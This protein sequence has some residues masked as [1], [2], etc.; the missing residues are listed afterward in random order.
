M[1]CSWKWTPFLHKI[2]N[3]LIQVRRKRK[4]KKGEN[5]IMQK[6]DII[7]WDV[8][9]TLLNFKYSQRH[10]LMQCFEIF[11]IPI[12]EAVIDRYDQINDGYWKMLELGKMTKEE[13]LVQRFRT[14]FDELGVTGIDVAAFQNAYEEGVGSIYEYIENSIELCRDLQ[15]KCSQ[16]VVT[17]GTVKVQEKKLRISGLLECMDD[18]FISDKIG[19]P[20]PHP[21]FFQAC[22]EKIP[23]F[24]KNRTIIIGDSLTSDM[25]GGFG[26]GIATCWYNPNA[27]ALPS[28][29]RI[30]YDIRSLREVYGVLGLT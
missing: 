8:D 27:A 20:K 13:L 11:K 19:T 23:N 29:I 2:V 22:F 30:D 7:L 24:Q 1:R 4:E 26:A 5:T 25:K 18:V 21:D 14:L 9:G 3:W 15:G 17:N 6:Y 10:A 28:D 12:T 16:Y